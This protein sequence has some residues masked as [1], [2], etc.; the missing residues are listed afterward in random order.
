MTIV[1]FDECW[2]WNS[3]YIVYLFLSSIYAINFI[4]FK[5][6]SKERNVHFRIMFKERCLTI[7]YIT[8]K[9]ILVIVKYLIFNSISIIII[10]Y[11]IVWYNKVQI[12]RENDLNKYSYK[13]SNIN[14]YLKKKIQLR[15]ITVIKF[16]IIYFIFRHFIFSSIF[17]SS[18]RRLILSN[19]VSRV[20]KK[21]RQRERE[22]DP[23]TFLQDPFRSLII[24]KHPRGA[25]RARSRWSAAVRLFNGSAAVKYRRT[26][27]G[28][29]GLDPRCLATRWQE[30]KPGV[31][32]LYCKCNL[33]PKHSSILPFVIE[34]MRTRPAKVP[35]KGSPV[36]SWVRRGKLYTTCGLR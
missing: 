31:R 19:R 14:Y 18:A 26:F 35:P 23:Q 13:I 20:S 10:K 6:N 24:I 9:L 8:Y 11:T 29:S 7:S 5:L 1:N 25:K 30:F 4:I 28:L 34:E 27:F 16:Q 17:F 12:R 2:W 15:L 36:R 32:R 33:S 22:N 3:N 21:E